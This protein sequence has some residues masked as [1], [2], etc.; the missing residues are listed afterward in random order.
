MKHEDLKELADRCRLIASNA[1][2]FT[3]K[4]LLE[5]ALAYEARLE[6]RSLASKKL[7][8]LTANGQDGAS[9][10]RSDHPAR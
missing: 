10:S 6:G 3:K 8:S 1:D 2:D 4:R 9:K 7:L 5:L